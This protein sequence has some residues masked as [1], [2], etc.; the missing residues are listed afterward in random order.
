MLKSTGGKVRFIEKLN[1]KPFTRQVFYDYINILLVNK[2]YN[3]IYKREQHTFVFIVCFN[4]L[5]YI[6][7]VF[8]TDLSLEQTNVDTHRILSSF[9]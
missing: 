7:L 3:S 1:V 9:R 8:T 2:T 4:N 5:R 6:F